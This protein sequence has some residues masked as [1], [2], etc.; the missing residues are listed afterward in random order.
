[1]AVLKLLRLGGHLLRGVLTVLV[2]FPRLDGEQRGQRVS[3]WTL[4]MLGIMDVR[5]VC[6]GQVPEQD[7][8]GALLVANHVSWLDIHVLHSLLPVRFVSKS[9]VRDWPLI[10]WLAVQVGTVF[11]MRAKK[12]DTLRVNQLMVQHLR[13]RALLA[14]FPEGTTTDG[15]QLLPFYPSLFQP[16]LE[17][18][19]PVWPA[20]LRYLDTQGRRSEA[21]AYY[22]DMSL[23]DSLWRVLRQGGITVEV[24]FLPRIPYQDGLGRRE[25]ARLCET[26]IREGPAGDGRSPGTPDRLPA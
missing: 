11:L 26:I 21:A 17:A 6:R 2:L 4:R 23:A 22:G 12:S 16:V 24:E 8:T 18:R 7:E 19:A 25:L 10:G 5:V 1:M 13:E 9:E 14:L 3:R 15:G 20:R